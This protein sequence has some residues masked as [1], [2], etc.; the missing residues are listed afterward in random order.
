MKTHSRRASR[1][2]PLEFSV[3]ALARE[4]RCREGEKGRE[5][6]SF[7]RSFDHA[8]HRRSALRPSGR[9]RS[10]HRQSCGARL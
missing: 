6:L 1:C 8:T 3:I 10:N 9:E 7:P 5:G 2:R 4:E